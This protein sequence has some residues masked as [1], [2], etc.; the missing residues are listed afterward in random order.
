MDT[1]QAC[2]NLKVVKRDI[3]L[4]I[5]K[6]SRKSVSSCCPAI[7]NN[8]EKLKI[9]RSKYF[10][11][12]CCEK[13]W[14]GHGLIESQPVQGECDKMGIIFIEYLNVVTE[15]SQFFTF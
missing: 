14:Y 4:V 13:T 7:K 12:G 15:V 6:D 2:L 8:F 1:D 9:I 11:Q 5:Q 3:N 10:V